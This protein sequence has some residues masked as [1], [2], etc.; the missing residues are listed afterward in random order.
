MQPWTDPDY[1]QF[2]EGV[3]TRTLRRAQDPNRADFEA[4]RAR[5]GNDP[6]P[7]NVS[8]TVDNNPA[9]MSKDK[10]ERAGR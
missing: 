4:R 6:S 8:R 5:Y 9:W 10:Q 2:V 3:K 7:P 1:D